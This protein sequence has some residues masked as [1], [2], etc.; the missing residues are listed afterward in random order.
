MSSHRIRS[1][2][3]SLC[4]LALTVALVPAQ[5]QAD[6]PNAVQ[7]LAGCQTNTFGANDDSSLSNVA[8]PFTVN[9]YGTSFSTVNINNNGNV[10]FDA[11]VGTYTPYDFTVTGQSIIAP[12]LSDVDTRGS[13]QVTYGPTM[14][15]GHEAFCVNW[16]DVGY[17][18]A[19]ADKTNSYQLLLI[20][21]GPNPGDFVIRLNYDRI[22]WETGDASG[23]SN[24]FGGASA[25]SGFSSGDGDPNHFFIFA[26][27]FVNGALLDGGQNALTAGTL[28]AGGQ[29]G[30][31]NFPIVNAPPTGAT[32]S[33]QVKAPGGGFL[34]NAPVQ[35][36]PVGGGSCL[37]RF[38]NSQGIYRALN[39]PADSYQITGFAPAGGPEYGSGQAGPVAVSGL[40]S[41]SQ[42]VTLGPAPGAPPA[43][44]EIT[45]IGESEAGLPTLYWNEGLTLSTT[46]CP[47]ATVTYEIRVGGTVV[48]SGSMTE[49][50]AGSG[51][52]TASTAALYPNHGDGDVSIEI[53]CPG[54]TPD[55][56]IGF[57]IYID[58]SGVVKD[59]GN[60]DPIAGATV[61]LLRSGDAS[62]PFTQVPDGSAIMSPANRSNPGV[63]DAG[64]HFGW[65]VIAG[66]YKVAASADGCQ[67]AETQVLQIPPPVTDL[68]IELDCGHGKKPEEPKG[69]G[70]VT[71]P[72]GGSPSTQPTIHPKRK[73]AKKCKKKKH[74][75]R[76]AKRSKCGKKKH[77]ARARFGASAAELLPL[78]A[79]GTLFAAPGEAKS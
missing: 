29:L 34:P 13:N 39:L 1:R 71:S 17:Y 45:H 51:K 76:T 9:Y 49:S 69:G 7:S 24:G 44:T 58:P 2:V 60:G 8:L 36:C 40:G 41:F 63:T 28:N 66:F 79:T 10:T 78:E 27:S 42:D 18:S 3:V 62:G 31:Y 59:A 14:V 23:G 70:P 4:A 35:I 52:Y 68:A 46:G 75:H 57:G 74:G 37:A 43:G 48:R 73:H 5:A 26:G 12:H 6:G 55:E 54:V 30:R 64:G 16:V 53:D 50:P 21:D 67:A 19:H 61:T 15:E 56:T 25:A 20:K 77:H 32:L 65:D 38:T 22:S 11:P 33:G 72:G 47:G